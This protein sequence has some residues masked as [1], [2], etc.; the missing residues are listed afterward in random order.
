MPLTPP[1][2]HIDH[3]DLIDMTAMVDIVFFLLIFFLVTSL[4]AIESSLPVPS[5]TPRQG[6]GASPSLAPNEEPDDDQVIVSI[7]ARNQLE[8]DGVA[9]GGP[10]ELLVRLR[11][12]R[13]GA[14]PPRKMLVQG[15]EDATH[16]TAVA[17]L[18]VGYE[19]GFEKVGLSIS[20]SV[21]E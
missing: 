13:R 10:D 15:H 7:D 18:D 1:P 19:A 5:P 2:M 20:S 3:E 11:Q 12:L 21:P 14:S 17:V 16:G 6:A 8:V 9:V 4:K